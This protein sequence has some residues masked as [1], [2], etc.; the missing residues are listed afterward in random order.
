MSTGEAAKASVQESH[1]SSTSKIDIWNLDLQ[2]YESVLS[3]GKRA[4]DLPRL[5]IAILNAGVFPFQWT[6][7]P[8]GFET[9]LQVNYLATAI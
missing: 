1:P 9:G 7:S 4:A 6:T 2:S 8:N 3:I 5:D